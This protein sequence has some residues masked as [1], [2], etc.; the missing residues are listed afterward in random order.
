MDRQIREEGNYSSE[1]TKQPL[2]E[3]E[4]GITWSIF[5]E[6]ARRPLSSSTTFGRANFP[7]GDVSIRLPPPPPL[8]FHFP[9]ATRG[10]QEN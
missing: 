10:E 1:T 3:R 7:D 4:T 5:P 8:L 2:R 6:D 9:V